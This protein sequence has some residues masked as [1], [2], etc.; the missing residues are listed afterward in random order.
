M[1]ED[2][3]DDFNYFNYDEEEMEILGRS[4]DCS[5]SDFTAPTEH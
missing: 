2:D 1:D 3:A 5:G 4:E